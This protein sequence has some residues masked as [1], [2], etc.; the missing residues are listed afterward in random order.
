MAKEIPKNDADGEDM[1]IE[2]DVDEELALSEAT[3]Q[4]L[5]DLAG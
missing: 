2:L 5:A 4:D 3:D 1:P